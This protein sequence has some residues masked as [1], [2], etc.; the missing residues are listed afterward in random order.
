[1]SFNGTFYWLRIDDFK[2]SNVEII[3]WDAL[4]PL[5]FIALIAWLRWEGPPDD[6]KKDEPPQVPEEGERQSRNERT[7]KRS[8]KY[9][10]EL[11]TLRL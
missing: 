10:E 7:D 11:E 6:Q 1:L 9:A 8:N 4:G 3:A 2:M 5:S